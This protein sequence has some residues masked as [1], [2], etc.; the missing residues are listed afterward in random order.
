[1]FYRRNSYRTILDEMNRLQHEMDRVMTNAES[2]NGGATMTFPAMNIW[3]GE[4]GAVV[5]AE[6]PG[7]DPNDLDI[8]VLGET[9]T[10]RGERKQ[11]QQQG[12]FIYHRQERGYGKFSR[13]IQLPFPISVDHVSASLDRGI[14]KITLPR[15]EE[16]KP[17]KI[18]I[19]K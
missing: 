5:T 19:N 14:L 16:D 12:N 18:S 13:S 2:G 3:S 9:L 8:K 17:K 11:D 15:A 4:D 10:V 1:M 6:L 7:V